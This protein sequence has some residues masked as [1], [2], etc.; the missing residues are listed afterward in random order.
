MSGRGTRVK[1][2]RL[3][4]GRTPGG[5]SDRLEATRTSL[6]DTIALLRRYVIQ[7]TVAPLKHLGRVLAFGVSGA[8]L[9]ALGGLFLI[10]GALRLIQGES[11]T[12]FAGDWSFAPY[13]M[14]AVIG[15]ATAALFAAIGLRGLR[16]RDTTDEPTREEV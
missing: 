7:E 3:R 14:A 15:L 2:G 4:L 12:T 5:S 16:G 9:F 13:L 10:V 6:T 8:A 1:I 11:G